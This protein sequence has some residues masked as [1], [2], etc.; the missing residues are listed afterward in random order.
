[1]P[2]TVS[3]TI[4]TIRLHVDHSSLSDAQILNIINN[5]Q[6]RLQRETPYI[7]EEARV[8]GTVATVTT[9]L[10]Q[11]SLPSDLKSPVRWYQIISG[12]YYPVY[13]EEFHPAIDE[14][15]FSAD[16]EEVFR[17][18]IHATTGYLFPRITSA[19]S[20]EF[21]YS[22]MIGDFTS[23]TGS[24]AILETLP[25]ALEYAGIA[26]YY[27]GLGEGKRAE[28]WRVKA[29]DAIQALIKQ[30]HWRKEAPQTAVPTTYGT[31]GRQR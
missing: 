17:F 5:G 3:G 30:V 1:M 4:D 21:F 25:E 7:F 2:S 27:D 8:T 13:Y 20:Y 23:V 19:I 15:A 31:I 22:K 11:W 24:N 14:F 26:E 28:T 9:T 12:F 6:R 10:Q 18:S 29:A 16:S